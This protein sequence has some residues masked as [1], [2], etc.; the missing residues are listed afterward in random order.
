MGKRI[1]MTAAVLAVVMMAQAV[2]VQ[3]NVLAEENIMYGFAGFDTLSSGEILTGYGANEK[4]AYSEGDISFDVTGGY[5]NRAIVSAHE[6]DRKY[7]TMK[8]ANNTQNIIADF[9]NAPLCTEVPGDVLLEFEARMYSSGTAQVDQYIYFRNGSSNAVYITVNES[10]G[11]SAYDGSN[12]ETIIPA[13][14]FDTGSWY[15]FD[16]LIDYENSEYTVSVTNNSDGK[17]YVAGGLGFNNVAVM[18]DK[19]D[20]LY[21]VNGG[22]QRIDLD[23]VRLSYSK[24]APFFSD[25]NDSSYTGEKV[26]FTYSDA[27]EWES[28]VESVALDGELIDEESWSIGEGVF[29]LDGGLFQEPGT[30]TITINAGGYAQAM[31]NKIIYSEIDYIE[32]CA[33]TEVRQGTSL[34]EAMEQLPGTVTAALVNGSSIETE[35]KWNKYS[36]PEYDGYR[37]GEYVFS[38]ELNAL[39]K[40][41]INNKMVSASAALRVTVPE[42]TEISEVIGEYKVQAAEGDSI[43]DIIRLLPQ[44]V[45]VRLEDGTEADVYVSWTGISEPDY[46]GEKGVYTFFADLSGIPSYIENSR[47]VEISAE[48]TVMDEL[49]LIVSSHTGIRTE[50]N[51]RPLLGDCDLIGNGDILVGTAGSIGSSEGYYMT[52]NKTDLY[53]EKYTSSEDQICQRTKTPAMAGKLY[54]KVDGMS[55]A[56]YRQEQDIYRGE[57]RAYFDTV[58]KSVSITTRALQSFNETLENSILVSE[59][60][61][62]SD[63]PVTLK[64]TT[65]P[66]GANNG[67]SIKTGTQGETVWAYRQP[68]SVSE[69]EDKEWEPT[70]RMAASVATRIL[71][72]EAKLSAGGTSAVSEVVIPAHGSIIALSGVKSS[73]ADTPTLT[74]E[75]PTLQN[76][77]IINAISDE[78]LKMAENEHCDWW[79]SYW[80]RSYI[81]LEDEKLIEKYYYGAQYVLGSSNRKGRYAPGIDGWWDNDIHEWNGDYTLNYNIQ[82]PY[83]GIYSSNRQELG[84]SY[85]KSILKINENDG[86]KYAEQNGKQGTFFRTHY[87]VM[88]LPNIP[89]HLGQKTNAVESA[90]NFIKH[91]YY[92]YDKEFLN[93][94][95]PFLRD[96]ADFWDSDLVREELPDG[97]YRYSVIDSNVSEGSGYEYNAITALAYLRMFYGAMIEFS[98]TLGVD[99]DRTEKWQDIYEHL[100]DYPIVTY[101]GRAG[102][103][104][105]KNVLRIDANN[106]GY[107]L[108]PFFPSMQEGMDSELAQICRYTLGAHPTWYQ[109][110]SFPEVFT[111]AVYAGFDADYI[112]E[113]MNDLLSGSAPFVSGGS[114]KTNNGLGPELFIKQPGG[115]I[116]TVGATEAVNAMLVQS[117]DGYIKMFAN[118]NG[119]DAKF[120]RL[121]QIGAFLVDGELKD[122]I[123][124]EITIKSDAGN[125]CTILNPWSYAGKSLSVYD[126]TGEEIETVPDGDKYTFETEAGAIYRIEPKGG[127]P[128][129]APDSELHNTAMFRN[130]TASS[131]LENSDWSADGAVNTYTDSVRGNLG[132]SSSSQTGADHTEWYQIDLDNAKEIRRVDIYPRTDAGNEG[133]GF[134]VDFR[135]EVSEDGES[136]YTVSEMTGCSAPESG[137]ALQVWF[138]PVTARYVKLTADKL[139]KAGSEYRLQFA[140]I[141]VMAGDIEFPENIFEIV[142]LEYNS[143]HTEITGIN[144]SRSDGY[145]GDASVVLCV[146]DAMGRLIKMDI[147]KAENGVVETGG[148]TLPEE[149]AEY[150]VQCAVWSGLS[151]MKPISEMYAE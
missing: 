111:A 117:S 151:D 69:I 7:I 61:N 42:T 134:P 60:A 89:D 40:Y 125:P 93:E 56:S 127:L 51:S 24:S 98:D 118:W 71:G 12:A 95:Y 147:Y 121:R 65:T 107:N 133:A 96:I 11:V 47:G 57:I 1:K 29:E 86:K 148:F 145:F 30:Y 33:E 17:S 63:S 97:G 106:Y 144:L 87:I 128:E 132:Y 66:T 74:P 72:A 99:A 32:G 45:R 101:K 9:L 16:I 54:F 126:E 34:Q 6:G 41:I 149:G 92:T 76:V 103:S 59:V 116:E 90:A 19:F 67:G 21:I 78:D 50:P 130:V 53:T 119:T 43:E 37:E 129:K 83:Y 115:G 64:V 70:F 10:T 46:R 108:Y 120:R 22:N 114:Q 104:Y 49:E 20:Q 3:Y 131:S 141:Q 58:D 36:E 44:T 105:S 81:E 62:D 140:E 23:N 55:G 2:G 135:I 94:I 102:F 73:G 27:P 122:G 91:Y 84:Y 82:A 75:D 137:N 88:G 13:D 143:E 123:C 112:I 52:I 139:S 85:Y 142:S 39:P 113:K 28:A 68:G 14:K 110:N 124:Q 5:A 31:I 138:E 4:E 15:S 38:G 109:Q 146:K 136:W 100:S 77:E 48:V 25:T 8:Y 26:I 18:P 80:E 150:T 79:R 35:V